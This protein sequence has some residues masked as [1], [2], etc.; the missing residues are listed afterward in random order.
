MEMLQENTILKA[1]L[2]KKHIP[3]LMLIIN[4]RDIHY[5]YR[6][7][8]VIGLGKIGSAAVPELIKLLDHSFPGMRQ[9]AA[10]ALGAIGSSAHHAS[11]S[12]AQ[13]T[14]DEDPAVAYAAEVALKQVLKPHA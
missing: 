6:H 3:E 4:N 1:L 10:E 12:L 7:D 13:V 2:T 11:T 14:C 8:A 9:A 5:S